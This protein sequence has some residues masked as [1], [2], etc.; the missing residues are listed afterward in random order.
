MTELILASASPRR[1]DILRMMGLRFRIQPSGVSE[2]LDAP[3][4]PPDHVL[5]ISRRKAVAVAR[6]VSDATPVLGADTVVAL[7]SQILEKPEDAADARRMLAQLSGKT[8]QVY[9]GLTLAALRAGRR[10]ARA[11]TVSRMSTTTP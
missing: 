11:P 7:G 10:L 4:S 2:A 1:A 5:Q 8:H 6:S 9:T 3:V